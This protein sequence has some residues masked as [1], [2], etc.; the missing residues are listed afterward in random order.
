MTPRLLV[1]TAGFGEGHNA[2][3]RALAEAWRRRHGECSARVADVFEQASPRLNRVSRRTYLAL[4]NRWPRVWSAC[5]RWLDHSAS[6]ATLARMLSD[7]RRELAHL[8]TDEVPDVICSTYPVYSYLL[9]QISWRAEL[10]APHFNIVTDSISIN[11]LW[12]RAGADG[13]FVPNEDS[14]EVMRGAGVDRDRIHVEGFPVAPV[15]HDLATR[16]V[17]P[18]LARGAR[19]RVLFIINSS[20][21]GAADAARKLLLETAWD[22]TCTVGRNEVLRRELEALAAQRPSPTRIVGWTDQIPS[23]LLSHHVVISK[24]GGATTQEALAARCP[25]IV[26]QIIPGQEE[27][28]YELLR[29][30]G[31]G[32][33]AVSPELLVAELQRAFADE[34]RVWTQWT[35][36]LEP[37]ARPDAA[38][39]IADRVLELAGSHLRPNARVT[40]LAASA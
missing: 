25:M 24:A 14:A 37:L 27:G 22:I 26:N 16:S 32:A 18:D 19:P 13:W 17:R 34:G 29:R 7:E 40:T 35:R 15:F 23:L 11:S 33:L 31:I 4:I 39:R 5:Y 20:T 28:N 36:A 12:W 1:L 38:G 21:R 3:A 30:H 9:R 6:F 10:K 2:A 8:L